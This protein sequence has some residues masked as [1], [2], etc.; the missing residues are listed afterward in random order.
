MSSP[1]NPHR[2]E[3]S[4]YFLQD[5][6]NEAELKRL[7]LQD[8][9][10]TLIMGGYLPEQSDPTHFQRVLDVACGTGGWLIELATLA[11][12]T[13]RYTGVDIS[14][15][16]L[17]TARTHARAQQVNERVTFLQMDALRMLEF[18]AASFDL[19]NQRFAMSYMRTWDWRKLLE[20]F[21]RIARPGGVIRLTESDLTY[22]S[23]SP[24]LVRLFHQL[25]EALYSSGHLFAR[26]EEGIADRLAGLL[27]QYAGLRDVQTRVA[28]LD[29]RAGTPAGDLFAQ[30]MI[31]AFQT[32]LPFLQK[33]THVPADY[34]AL[35]QQMV[36]EVQQPD[37]WGH[38]HTVTAWG[39]R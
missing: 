25:G 30:D 37:F 7:R 6:S 1:T 33:W 32:S 35:Y 34:E 2:E 16:M 24:A 26:H 19:V 39:T 36:T 17:E 29:Y 12:R 27:Q 18:P 20:E 10:A 22:Q 5:R 15:R 31:H 14:E 38:A 4:T 28:V 11:P 3:P 8:Q 13:A 21:H 9:M 23:S